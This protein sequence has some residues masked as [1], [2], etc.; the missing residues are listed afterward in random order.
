MF[1]WY[2]EGMNGDRIGQNSPGRVPNARDLTAEIDRETGLALAAQDELEHGVSDREQAVNLG[3]K[4]LTYNPNQVSE[5][6]QQRSR[7]DA[8]V[9]EIAEQDTQP[10]INDSAILSEEREAWNHENYLNE[11]DPKRDHEAKIMA[12]DQR[13]IAQ[14]MSE[15]VS[16]A[17]QRDDFPIMDLVLL[18]SK[19]RDRMLESFENPRRLGDMN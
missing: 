13:G 16:K 14:E 2:N 12:H 5:I 1:L 11:L 7:E 19:G 15:L 18:Q 10:A 8:R 6:E 9:R 17:T 4:I 3:N